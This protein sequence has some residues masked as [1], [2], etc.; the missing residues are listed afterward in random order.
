MAD[1]ERKAT[2]QGDGDPS[3]EEQPQAEARAAKP[4][5]DMQDARHGIPGKGFDA[6]TGY[7]GAGGSSA[8]S[9]ESSYGGQAGYGGSTTR[10]AYAGGRF[11]RPDDPAGPFAGHGDRVAGDDS[12]ATGASDGGEA[13]DAGTSGPDAGEQREPESR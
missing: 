8:Y 5:G 12:D 7:G 13:S 9:G 1:K 2:R 3:A 11:G 6:G 4:K 10:G